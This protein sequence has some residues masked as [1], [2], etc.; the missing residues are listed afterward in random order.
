MADKFWVPD[1]T[2]GTGNTSATTHWDDVSGG[3]GG[4][5][6][7]GAGDNMKFDAASFLAAS[8]VVTVDAAANCLNMD[9]T[10][11]TNSP[12]LAF[13]AVLNPYGNV[14]FIAAMATSGSGTAG[15]RWSNDGNLTTNGLTITAGRLGLGTVAG[16]TLTLNDNLT[17]VGVL[18]V[19]R[20]TLNTNGKT[21]TCSAMAGDNA[22]AKTITLG[23]S[24]V[25]TTTSWAVDG[26]TTTLT[27]NTSTINCS[28]NFSGGGLTTYNIVNLTGA[29]STITGNN[30]IKEIG[31]M[32]AGVQTITNT[33]ATQ[34]V[35]NMRRDAG[36]TVKTLVNGT[37][38]NVGGKRIVLPYMSI[39]GCTFTPANSW[40]FPNST[41][42]G[43][44][45]NANFKYPPNGGGW[46]IIHH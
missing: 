32:R 26:A 37:Y 31:L 1:A 24:A 5:V 13:N 28:G 20:G 19:P 34:T 46:F 30:T 38:V 15:L 9:W 27:A 35:F 39:S 23:N 4:D 2:N 21:V 36:I 45:T 41:D 6:V 7:P 12:T 42:G 33:G 3:A 8:Q 17:L 29:T 16:K 22:E 40:Y 10:G 44:N 25:T 14:T 18:F 11:A 43:T